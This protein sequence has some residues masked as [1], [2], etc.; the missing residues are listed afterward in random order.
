MQKRKNCFT[1]GSLKSKTRNDNSS[2]ETQGD[3]ALRGEE[4]WG[5]HLQTQRDGLGVGA[6]G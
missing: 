1:V 3:D 4:T 5:R 2:G 6:W